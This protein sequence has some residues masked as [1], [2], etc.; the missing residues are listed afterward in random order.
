MEWVEFLVEQS[1]VEEALAAVRYYERIEW[2][3]PRAADE[4][5]AILE[6]H[7]DADGVVEPAE[8]PAALSMDHHIESLR[9]IAWLNG[10]VQHQAFDPIGAD[11]ASPLLQR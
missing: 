11:R 9:Y 4:L 1:T 3:A 7:P 6:G 5:R 2:I 10:D 8:W